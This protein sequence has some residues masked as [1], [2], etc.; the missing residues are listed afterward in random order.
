MN[1]KF[2]PYTPKPHPRLDDIKK[3]QPPMKT[4]KGVGNWNQYSEHM[5]SNGNKR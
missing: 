5:L 4:L 1:S 3:S 2:K